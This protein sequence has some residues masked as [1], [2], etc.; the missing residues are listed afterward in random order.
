MKT[1]IA[2][3]GI[4]GAGKT[5]RR[6]TDPRLKNLPYVDI[7]D[8]YAEFE[9][10]NPGFA[11]GEALRRVDGLLQIHEAVIFEAAFMKGSRQRDT[12]YCFCRDRQF[13]LEYIEIK[14][15]EKK[16][17]LQ[18]ILVDFDRSIELAVTDEQKQKAKRYYD[19][20]KSFVESAA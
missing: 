17:L 12:L 6:N 15:P 8:V 16:I 10:V 9:G 3:S 7:A 2:L 5:H 1:I 18:R 19:A 14:P 4:S 20:R 11:F 13:K